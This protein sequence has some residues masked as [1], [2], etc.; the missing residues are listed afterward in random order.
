[1]NFAYQ[2]KNTL[3]QDIADMAKVSWFFSRHPETDFSRK[4][5]IDF[6]SLLH[7]SICMEAGTLRHELLKYFS[8]DPS[9]LSNSAFYQ[10]R[11][12]L[13]PETFPFL[14]HQ[15]NSHFP[16]TL[17]KG[18]YRLL[19]CDGSAFTFT[20]NP[21]DPESYFPPDGKSTNGYNQVHLVALFDLLSRRFT[22]C[23]VQPIR[24]KNEFLALTQM[25]DRCNPPDAVPIFI[26]D[27][28]F[29]SFNVFA[30]AIEHKAYFLIRAKDVNMRR[31]LGQDIPEENCFDLWINRILTRSQSKKK[32]KHPELE[33]QYRFICRDVAFDYI[34]HGLGDEYPISLRV[35]RFKISNDTYENIITNLPASSFSASEIKS[36]YELRWGIETSFR[37]LKHVIGAI[38]FHSK[39]REY[40]EMEIWARLLL[41]NFCSIITSHVVIQ[42]KKR[43]YIYQVNY[44]VAY[45]ACHYLLRLHHGEKP[46]DI[47]S[48]I[49]Q[50]ILPIRPGR[51]YARQ[52]RFRVPVSFTYRF[53]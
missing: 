5:K 9:T 32:R 45:D 13:L 29:H 25:I 20:R 16:V 41:Y 35:L 42:Q 53:T 27:R 33:E 3:L 1:M 17:Y 7:F 4:R 48:L 28:G 14:F 2:V 47:E 30:H 19:A 26:A 8:Y 38:N 34:D 36:L 6:Q 12:K 18:K 15:F 39:K 37:E 11:K 50:N 44:T 22:D 23:T 43:K 46:P 21:Q 49:G 52:H 31:L 10:Q 24:K 40:I 51:K